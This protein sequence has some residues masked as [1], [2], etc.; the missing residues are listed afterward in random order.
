MQHRNI[1]IQSQA[2]TQIASTFLWIPVSQRMPYY[3][4][5]IKYFLM[6]QWMLG[7]VIDQVFSLKDFKDMD[8]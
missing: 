6:M 2:F 1:I 7:S 4:V 5:N 8:N 3:D